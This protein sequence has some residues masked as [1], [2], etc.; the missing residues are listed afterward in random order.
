M[1]INFYKKTWHRILLEKILKQESHLITGNILDVGSG[2]RRYDNLFNGEIIAIDKCL[3]PKLNIIKANF[4]QKTKFVDNYF[5]GLISIEVFEYLENLNQP[6]NEVYR[7]LKPGHYA[8]IT[9]PFMYHDHGDNIRYTKEYIYSQ[10]NNFSE[11]DVKTIGNAYTVI[12]DIIRKKVFGSKKS[13][14]KKIIFIFLLPILL[15]LKLF[16]VEKIKDSYYSGIFIKLK[17]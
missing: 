14:N 5:D 10:T 17:K 1:F 7:L 3:N 11:V 2:S 4:N 9:M 12:W 8:L 13:L 16:K 6:I 15:I